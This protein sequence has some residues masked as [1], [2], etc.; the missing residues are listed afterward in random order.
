MRSREGAGVLINIVAFGAVVVVVRLSVLFYTASASASASSALRS[1]SAQC[2]HKTRKGL[3]AQGTDRILSVSQ[4]PLYFPVALFIEILWLYFIIL[5]AKAYA[6]THP[7]LRFRHHPAR[8]RL[9]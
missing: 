3:A 1:A 7:P 5:G 9:V 8:V 6:H 2:A 4:L